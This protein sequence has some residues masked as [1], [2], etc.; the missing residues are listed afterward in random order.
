MI[1]SQT[2]NISL[3]NVG[4][5]DDLDVFMENNYAESYVNM[6]KDISDYIGFDKEIDKDNL[7]MCYVSVFGSL[8]GFNQYQEHPYII[9]TRATLEKWI[10][11]N[12]GTFEYVT[13]EL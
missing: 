2:M 8:V 5:I 11:D 1:I 13:D 12:S 3:P 6:L 10:T 4:T 9:E 7:K